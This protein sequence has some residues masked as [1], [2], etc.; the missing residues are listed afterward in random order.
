MRGQKSEIKLFLITA[1]NQAKK[2]RR[3][4]TNLMQK[5]ET[6]KVHLLRHAMKCLS[7]TYFQIRRIQLCS[8]VILILSL[9][10]VRGVVRAITSPGKN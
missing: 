3:H 4:G 5:C 9:S 1:L 10:L 2:V 6:K 8:K 7:D